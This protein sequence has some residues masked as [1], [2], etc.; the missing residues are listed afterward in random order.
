M[1]VK[2]ASEEEIQEQ[3]YGVTGVTNTER[4]QEYWTPD[5]REILAS[6]AMREYITRNKE[7]KAIG[8]GIRDANLDK[9]WL[10]QPPQIPKLE[11][12]YC[13]KWHDTE[14]EMIKCAARKKTSDAKYLKR[15]KKEIGKD[16]D[17]RVNQLESDMSEIK[18]LLQKLLEK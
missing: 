5:G 6:P 18:G 17:S 4:L 12:G 9:G 13:D 7:G 10:L 16:S 14:E 1:L 15:A 3:G 8:G 2:L 11:C